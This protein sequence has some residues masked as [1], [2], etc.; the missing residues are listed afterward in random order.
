MDTKQLTRGAMM[1]GI[2]GLLLFLNQQT[3]L[4]IES[5]ASWIFAFPIL[6]YAAMYGSKSGSIVAISMVLM[7]FLFGGFTTWFYS[8]S[9]ILIGYVYG[10]GVYKQW[11]HMTNFVIAAFLSIIATALMI[12]LWA[13]IF[14][15][16]LTT[17]FQE[18]IQLVP[19]IHLNVLI[20]VVVVFMGILQ[21]LC[22][23]LVALMVCIRMR[24][25]TRNITPV[26]QIK[27]PRWLGVVSLVLLG[28]YYFSQNVLHLYADIQ[29]L[30]QILVIFDC[31]LL[32]YYGVIYFMSRV[33]DKKRR[34]LSFLAII[35]AFIPGVFFI[36]IIAGELD[37]L[38]Q[39]RK[40]RLDLR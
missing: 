1:C 29:D 7:T 22:I 14:G 2:Y 34:N 31:A 6:I 8:W 17:D 24:I 12:Y 30:L 19:A 33:V 18:I 16:D 35:G 25:T 32:D 27:S 28:F 9:S 20:F 38:L 4:T 23:H 21:G 11:K 15:Y 26:S 3:A 39:L 36:W 5:G 13:G 10:L 37:C 40:K